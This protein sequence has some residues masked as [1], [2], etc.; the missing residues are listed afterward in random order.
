MLVCQCLASAPCRLAA[1]LSPLRRGGQKAVCA[2]LSTVSCVS[3]PTP[4]LYI[5]TKHEWAA[6][7]LFFG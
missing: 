7:V 5:S 2:H 6:V 1:L 4:R 3:P